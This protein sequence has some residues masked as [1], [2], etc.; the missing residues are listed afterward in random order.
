MFGGADTADSNTA[1]VNVT[2]AH[3]FECYFTGDA[4]SWAIAGGPRRS[5]GLLVRKKHGH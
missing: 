1:G 5:R 4:A 2:G 3:C